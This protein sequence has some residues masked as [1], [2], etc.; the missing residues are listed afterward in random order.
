MIFATHMGT[1]PSAVG[2]VFSGS[3]EL[4]ARPKLLGLMPGAARDDCCMDFGA[5][6]YTVIDSLRATRNHPW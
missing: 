4:G 1:G 2:E 6:Q 5:L 3:D